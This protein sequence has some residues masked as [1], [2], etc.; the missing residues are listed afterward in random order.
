MIVTEVDIV[1]MLVPLTQKRRFRALAGL[2][3]R[4]KIPLNL[5]E[6]KELSNDE[7]WD[8]FDK[9]VQKHLKFQE[10]AKPQA[11]KLSGRWQPRHGDN[12]DFNLGE[13]LS[14]KDLSHLQG[15]YLLSWNSGRS[16]R[17]RRK[18]SKPHLL[19]SSS[20]NFEAGTQVRTTWVQLVIM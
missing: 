3:A 1:G 4:Q 7:K 2:V 20:K 12:S 14:E 9:H 19:V 13:I 15:T 11:F 6:I 16:S 18:P 8:L 17:N 10:D 5:P